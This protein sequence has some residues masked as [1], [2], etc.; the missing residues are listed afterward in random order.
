MNPI[1][2][3]LCWLGLIEHRWVHMLNVDARAGLYRCRRCGEW[4]PGAPW[5]YGQHE[6]P[7]LT[8]RRPLR[9]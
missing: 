6:P 2:M 4:S 8:Y 7:S 9:H 3:V 5:V 1:T